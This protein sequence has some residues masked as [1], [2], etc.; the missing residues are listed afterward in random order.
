MSLANIAVEGLEVEIQ[1]PEVL[2]FELAYFEFDGDQAGEATVEEQQVEREVLAADLERHL[3][4]D[5]T[6]VA[7]QAAVSSLHQMYSSIFQ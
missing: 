6:E 1:L 5:E 7:P 4:P 3:A 2:R